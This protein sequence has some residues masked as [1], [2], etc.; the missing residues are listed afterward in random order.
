MTISCR[1]GTLAC[2]GR[3]VSEVR[4][5]EEIEGFDREDRVI[6]FLDLE[7][8]LQPRIDTVIVAAAEGVA[9][10]NPVPIV[11]VVRNRR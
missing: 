1:P 6:L 5:I 10:D 3:E 8:F 4:V 7:V 2:G 9:S 11:R